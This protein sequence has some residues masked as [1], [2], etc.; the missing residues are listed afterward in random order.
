MRKRILAIAVTAALMSA[1]GQS[2]SLTGPTDTPNPGL[3]PGPPVFD[4]GNTPK[5]TH[6]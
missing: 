3:K 4:P 5:G 1:C 6:G 2:G